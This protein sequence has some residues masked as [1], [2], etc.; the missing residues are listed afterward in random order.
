MKLKRRR[1]HS[2]I[3]RRCLMLGVTLCL[4]ALCV[5]VGRRTLDMLAQQ[6]A[7]SVKTAVLRSAMQC[8]AVEG[9]YPENLDY[10]EKQYGLIVNHNRY[11]ITYE[12]FSSNLLPEVSVLPKGEGEA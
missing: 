3:W 9:V 7:A 5:W 11:I 2:R 1:K 4:V 8:Y 12:A 6:S 10:L